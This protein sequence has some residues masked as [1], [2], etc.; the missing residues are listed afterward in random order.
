MGW[1]LIY[2]GMIDRMIEA[3]DLFLNQS[4]G[5]IFPDRLRYKCALIW[6]EYQKDEKM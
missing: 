3:R 2:D 1:N 4:T 5:L 6:D